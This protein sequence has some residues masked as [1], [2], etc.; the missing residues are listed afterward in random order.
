M[1][2]DE[3]KTASN[4][5]HA[6]IVDPARNMEAGDSRAGGLVVYQND[7]VVFQ[8]PPQSAETKNGSTRKSSVAED[9]GGAA[10]LSPEVAGQLLRSRVEPQYPPEALEA[11]I[12]GVI[13]IRLTVD[14]TGTVQR[15]RVVSGPPELA[16]AAVDAVKQ[17][18]FHPYSPN[19]T[20]QEFQT[21]ATIDFRLP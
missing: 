3:T 12:Q 1:I 17:W 19:G 4:A 2:R 21:T 14:R 7:R 20:A 16:Q 6:G 15:A 11:H 10:K 5:S 13:G 9:V 18:R 8:I